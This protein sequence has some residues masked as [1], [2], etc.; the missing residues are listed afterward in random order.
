MAWYICLIT[1]ASK[2]FVSRTGLGNTSRIAK[3]INF[4]G[5]NILDPKRL[6]AIQRH[7]KQKRTIKSSNLVM[8][9]RQT[10][11]TRVVLYLEEKWKNERFL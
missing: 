5:D 3:S 4:V 6:F 11:I 2:G 9:L 1:F 10:T 8:E 7:E